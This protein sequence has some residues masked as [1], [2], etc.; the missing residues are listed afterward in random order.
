MIHQRAGE[1]Q[2]CK[3]FA[4]LGSDN[5]IFGLAEPIEGAYTTLVAELLGEDLFDWLMWWMYETGNGTQTMLFE[6]DNKSYD[7]TT[8][9]LYR[10]L[11]LVDAD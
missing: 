1:D 2:V 6:I 7:P 11:E 8:M 3:A 4:A 9:T 10:F 5:A